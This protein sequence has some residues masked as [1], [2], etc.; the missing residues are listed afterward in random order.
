[1]PYNDLEVTERVFAEHPGEIAGMLLEPVMM[2]AG[3][4]RPSP[5]TWRAWPS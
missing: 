4:I 3:I 5:A 1:M 2:N